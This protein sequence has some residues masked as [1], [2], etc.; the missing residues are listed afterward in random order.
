MQVSVREISKRLADRVESVV[1]M[2]L[3]GGKPSNGDW[4]C[5]DISGSSGKSLKVHLT[6]AHTGEWRDW[7][8]DEHKGDLLDLWRFTKG[9]TLPDAIAEAK[10]FL[11]IHDNVVYESKKFAR[12]DSSL[13][14]PITPDGRAMAFLK[15]VR[16]LSEETIATFKIQVATRRNAIAFPCYSPNGELLNRSYRTVPKNGEPKEVWQDGKCAPCLFGWHALPEKAYLSRTVLISEGQI[17]CMTWHQWGI[18]ALSLPNGTGSSWIEFEWENLAAFDHIYLSF[19]MDGAGSEN[20]S[21]IIDRLGKHRCLRVELP[22]KDANDCLLAGYGS[23]DAALWVSKA[24]PPTVFGVVMAKDLRSR[25]HEEIRSKTEP[26]T[27]PFFRVRWPYEGFYPH[28][29]DVTVWLG[30]TGHGKTTFLNF[31]TLGN[32]ARGTR[33]FVAS[34]EVTPERNIRKMATALCRGEMNGKLADQFLDDAGELLIFADKVGYIDRKELMEMMWFSYRRHG[35]VH[36]LIDSLMRVSGLEEDYPAQG[37]FMNELQAFAKS[38][39]TFV[40]L[41]CHP[42]KQAEGQRPGQ[43]DVKGS[44]LIANNADNIVSITRNFEK[45]KKRKEG[46]LTPEQ[47]MMYHDAEIRVEKQREVGWTGMFRLRFDPRTFSY[48]K[49]D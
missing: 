39:K 46:T 38:T 27:A 29:G 24:K 8:T 7:S 42:R 19:D 47:D 2:L 22:R 37:D 20:V 30:P 12:P 16:K 48:K 34:M 6:G 5:G 26:F 31:L 35:C 49:V 17:D 14:K 32:I 4:V 43:M 3:P 11:G 28:P 18:P 40:N 23:E 33:N 44:S 15:E 41:V 21:K 9:I 1:P 13:T 25:V 36:Y 45:E 10:G